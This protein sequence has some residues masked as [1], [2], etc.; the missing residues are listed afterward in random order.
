MSVILPA[1]IAKDFDEVRAKAE[2]V[3]GAV[4]LQLDVID[5][6]FSSQ[7]SWPYA[8]DRI[9]DIS[10]VDSLSIPL[11]VHLMVNNPEELAGE[12]A[13]CERVSR[14]VFHFEATTDPWTAIR[15]IQSQGKEV[16]IALK[17][18]TPIEVV[19]E[20]ADEINALL[21]MSIASV[22]AHGIPFEQGIFEKLHAA[23][24]AYPELSIGIDGGVNESNAQVL[25]EDGADFLIIGSA[26]FHADNPA[27]ALA[28]F[29]SIA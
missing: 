16:G 10:R 12:W 14:V 19:R 28:Q 18:E 25:A 4:M 6:L 15:D 9:D 7:K 5:G 26:I 24:A 11:E 23:Q 17:Y 1:I 21:L 20:Y 3:S 27:F 8:A 29:Q 2:T 22:G 13:A